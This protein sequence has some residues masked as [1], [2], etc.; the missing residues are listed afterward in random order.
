MA[1]KTLARKI[2]EN[3]ERLRKEREFTQKELAEITGIPLSS[4]TGYAAGLREPDVGRLQ[5]LANVLDTTINDLLGDDVIFRYRRKHAFDLAKIALLSPN[6]EDNGKIT[7]Q[8]TEIK[9]RYEGRDKDG[10]GMPII[11]AT[12]KFGS[13]RKRNLFIP[14][15]ESLPPPARVA[16][17]TFPTDEE[18]VTFVEIVEDFAIAADMTFRTAFVTY[19]RDFHN[20]TFPDDFNLEP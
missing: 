11:T 8:F 6:V 2:G 1:D 20:I 14:R 7:L 19:L 16:S 12:N 4:Y 5:R 17:V 18:F 3:L 15:D 9:Q 13:V 10:L